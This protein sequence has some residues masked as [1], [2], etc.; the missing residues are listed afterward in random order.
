MSEEPHVHAWNR[1][2]RPCS[3]GEPVPAYLS[4]AWERYAERHREG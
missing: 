3:C 4:A 1:D 2:G